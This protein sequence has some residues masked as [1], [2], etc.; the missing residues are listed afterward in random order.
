M[1]DAL[2]KIIVYEVPGGGRR[3]IWRDC[4][5]KSD[6]RGKGEGAQMPQSGLGGAEPKKLPSAKTFL[7]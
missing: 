6:P 3:R 7:N 4:Q 5:A 1:K 2:S